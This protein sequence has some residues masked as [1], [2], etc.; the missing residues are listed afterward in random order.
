[1]ALK[2]CKECGNQ[3][4][5]K[6]TKCPICGI[7]DPFG[8]IA[9]TQIG[10]LAIPAFFVA[11]VIILALF[12]GNQNNKNGQSD[13]NSDQTT[14]V[15]IVDIGKWGE[16]NTG[17]IGCPTLKELKQLG[18]N[19]SNNDKYGFYEHFRK[20]DCIKIRPGWRG[21]NLGDSIISSANKIRLVANEQV[22]WI[23]TGYNKPYFVPITLPKTNANSKNPEPFSIGE[24]IIFI[25]NIIGCRDKK[26]Y[27]GMRTSALWFICLTLE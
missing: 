15:Q 21:L 6:A 8:K 17:T 23:Y 19:Q 27:L 10:C 1:M 18:N 26:I 24:H 22:Y 7:R 2:P 25:D 4:S 12:N 3:I 14:R 16:F 11:V 13:S 20:Y 9:K 5:S